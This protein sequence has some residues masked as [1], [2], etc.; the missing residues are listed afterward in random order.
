[1]CPPQPCRRSR[2]ARMDP[3]ARSCLA[4]DRSR[5]CAAAAIALGHL[6]PGYFYTIG[7]FTSA[8]T[9]ALFTCRARAIASL[10][11]LSVL[12]QPPT[13]RTRR[14]VGGVLV[15]TCPQ[16]Q[17]PFSIVRW[18]TESCSSQWFR[19]SRPR[20]GRCTESPFCL[21]QVSTNAYAVRKYSTQPSLRLIASSAK[22]A[23]K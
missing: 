7:L 17:E 10:S 3:S 21:E 14:L 6:I 2:R 11:P 1:V 8:R 5:L 18:L 22:P 4:S 16:Q 12:D 13:F 23:A 15:T 20:C 9:A 19:S